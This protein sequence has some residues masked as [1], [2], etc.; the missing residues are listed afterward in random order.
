MKK[1][2]KNNDFLNDVRS[3][4]SPN[5]YEVVLNLVNEDREDLAKDVIKI[6]Y[7]LDYTSR[8]LKAKDK[9]EARESIERAKIRIDNILKEGFSIDYIVYLYEGI[10]KK[11]K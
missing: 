1:T 11:V 6:D 5:V 10:R 4:L 2:S 3:D 9:R 7:L 8:C